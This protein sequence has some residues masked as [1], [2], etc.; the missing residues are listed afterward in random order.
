MFVKI[1]QTTS[2][3]TFIILRI[4]VVAIFLSEGIQKFLFPA[5]RGTGRF[6]KIGIPYNDFMGN[7]VAGLEVVCGILILLGL[8]TRL[9][10]LTTL[11]IMIVAISTTKLPLIQH[12]GFWSM[13]HASRTDWSMLLG[14]V[15]LCINGGGKWSLDEFLQ[16]RYKK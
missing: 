8:L 13:A 1:T 3:P 15:F 5:L 9:G 4:M 12:E 16:K 10:A 7:F 6:E 14:S 11:I 2:N